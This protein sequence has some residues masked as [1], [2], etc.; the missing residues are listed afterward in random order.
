[1][2]DGVI[3]CPLCGSALFTYIFRNAY[4]CDEC[5]LDFDKHDLRIVP[6]WHMSPIQDPTEDGLIGPHYSARLH[7][8][9]QLDMEL[10]K[11]GQDT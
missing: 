4:A 3:C 2:N 7:P 11:H 8:L 1:M 10:R 6:G 9:V 5:C